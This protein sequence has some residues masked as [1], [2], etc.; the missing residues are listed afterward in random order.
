MELQG[1]QQG[2][3]GKQQ[4]LLPALELEGR[5]WDHMDNVLHS[6]LGNTQ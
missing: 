4:I 3:V 5:S 2:E 1:T 6:Q